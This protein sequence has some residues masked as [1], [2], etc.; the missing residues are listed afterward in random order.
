MKTTFISYCYSKI[1]NAFFQDNQIIKYLPLGTNDVASIRTTNPIPSS[2]NVFYYEIKIVNGGHTFSDN[3]KDAIGIGFSAKNVPLDRMPGWN[4]KSIGYHGDDGGLFYESGYAFKKCGPTFTTGDVVGCGINQSENS[5][6]FTKNGDYLGK[7]FHELPSQLY[8]MVGFHSKNGL[9]ETN[10][11]QDCF[12]FDIE[13]FRKNPRELR[14]VN[15]MLSYLNQ[16]HDQQSIV[17]SFLLIF[18]KGMYF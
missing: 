7:I 4:S 1:I 11:G 14:F 10:F 6:F 2:V 5:C 3:V 13:N 17:K 18:T 9:I 8:P 15:F 16:K 12:A